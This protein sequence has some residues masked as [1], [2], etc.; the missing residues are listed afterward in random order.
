MLS[1]IYQ[2]P[3]QFPG[4]DN[5]PTMFNLRTIGSEG[6]TFG[7]GFMS[8]PGGP[9]FQN[10]AIDHYA[11]IYVI[12]GKGIYKDQDNKKYA[13]SQG[14]IF[15]RIPGRIHSNHIDSNEEWFE[16]FVALGRKM[17][18]SLK[19]MGVFK[20]Q[21]PIVADSVNTAHEE[22]LL[23]QFYSI[24]VRMSSFDE[25]QILSILAEELQTLQELLN[26]PAPKNDVELFCGLVN[27]SPEKRINLARFCETQGWG[28]ESF[29]KKFKELMG[30]SP[31][32]YVVE[33][34]IDK[35]KHLLKSTNYQIGEIANLLGYSN[36]YEF[37]NQIK[38]FTNLSPSQF[39]RFG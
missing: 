31:G 36:Q 34:R 32:N 6:E 14:Q 38:K 1:G 39:R 17:Y 13:L 10:R 4:V 11:L 21:E 3:D 29:R 16:G 20:S 2:F 26:I 8:K 9:D 24:A 27:Q 33:I 18:D 30:K 19:A 37:S 15:Q 5:I 28:Y 35:A 22:R 7:A 23:K 25:S 12:K